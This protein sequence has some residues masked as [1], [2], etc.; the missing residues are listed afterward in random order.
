MKLA[1]IG[2]GAFGVMLIGMLLSDEYNDNKIEVDLFESGERLLR[3]VRASGNGRCNF[4]NANMRSQYYT[5]KM[6]NFVKH[7]LTEF[8][9]SR[10]CEY[11]KGLGIFSRRLESGMTYPATMKADTICSL[12][13]SRIEYSGVKVYTNTEVIGIRKNESLYYLESNSNNF[14]PYDIVVLATGGAYGIGKNEWSCAYSLAKSLGHSITSLHAGIVSLKVEE[15]DFCKRLVGEKVYAQVKFGNEIV[16]DD[17]LFTNYGISGLAILKISN[18]ILDSLS[19]KEEA[20]IEIDLLHEYSLEYLEKEIISIVKNR[21]NWTII[22]ALQGY[23]SKSILKE[24][25]NIIKINSERR[26]GEVSFNKIKE[27]IKLI[28]SLKFKIKGSRKKDHGQVTCGGISCQEIDDVSLESK[29][30]KNLYLGGEVIDVQGICGGYN[31][32]WAWTSAYLV[33]KD[34]RKKLKNYV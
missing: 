16:V 4:T 5:G 28:K 18:K 24:T 12:L 10:A 23:V 27:W 17:V 2:G 7:G 6:A 9:Y 20:Y 29:I 26:V 19:C 34:I 13:E 15:A 32:H 1:V 25:L 33:A 11:F 3:K 31:L 8:N 22:D 14:G 21:E 30:S